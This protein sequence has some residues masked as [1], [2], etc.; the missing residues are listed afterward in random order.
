MITP[1]TKS[2][3]ERES[4]LS[5]QRRARAIERQNR[6]L[7]R[8]DGGKLVKLLRLSILHMPSGRDGRGGTTVVWR[9]AHQH[10]RNVIEVSTALCAPTDTYDRGEGRFIAASRFAR[11]GTV[12]MR[13]PESYEPAEYLEVTLA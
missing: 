8:I 1:L 6:E 13:V 11:G 3:A 9:R 10:G 4:R 2:P 5:E 7:R 12:L